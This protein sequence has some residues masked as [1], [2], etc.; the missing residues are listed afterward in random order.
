[1]AVIILLNSIYLQKASL[2]K[3]N[4]NADTT[5][6]KQSFWENLIRIAMV[7]NVRCENFRED[8]LINFFNQAENTD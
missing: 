5:T 2:G 6:K 1:M 3:C 8:N 7:D 4:Q